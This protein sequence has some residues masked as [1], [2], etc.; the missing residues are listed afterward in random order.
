MY[1]K[2]STQSIV[3]SVIALGIMLFGVSPDVQEALSYY[4]GL[5]EDWAV[6]TDKPKVLGSKE[7]TGIIN[8]VVDGDTIVLEDGRTIRYLYVDTPETK[9]P[10]SPVMCYGKE[11]SA[12]NTSFTGAKV[13]L[14]KDKEATD[15]YGR[16]LRIVFLDGRNTD[17]VSQSIN[18]QLVK[19]GMATVKIYKPNDTFEKE[20]RVIEE[21][22]KKEKKGAWKSCEKPFEV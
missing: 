12:F 6:L 15:R 9:K 4:T 20:L 1:K 13:S 17:D 3:I 19:F 5:S 7:E 21:K 10:N 18:A 22:A 14:K 16:D 2:G 8:R 11:A